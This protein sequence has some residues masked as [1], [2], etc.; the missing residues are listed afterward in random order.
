MIEL[1]VFRGTTGNAEMVTDDKSG[2]KLPRHPFGE[3][4]FSRTIAV[5]AETRLIGGVDCRQVL[6]NVAKDGY[7]A[8]TVPAPGA[9]SAQDTLVLGKFL[10][11][12]TRLN[13]DKRNFASSARTRRFQTCS[14]MSLRSPIAS[15]TPATS[16]MTSFWR[17]RGA[18]WTPCSASINAR[19]GS[20]AIC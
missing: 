11:D 17:Q 2:N 5:A 20:R 1:Y 10:R 12:V 4:V 19:A 7:H 14:A 16:T 9:V 18:C 6:A 8:V 13:E 3:W 15:G